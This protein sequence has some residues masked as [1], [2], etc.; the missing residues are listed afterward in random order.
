MYNYFDAFHAY[1]V[2][3]IK[4]TS[5]VAL[6]RYREEFPDTAAI[7]I[8]VLID[9]KIIHV[10]GGPEVRTYTFEELGFTV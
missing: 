7:E 1:D 4:E 8:N 9:E 6:M 5:L 2:G 3:T 10:S